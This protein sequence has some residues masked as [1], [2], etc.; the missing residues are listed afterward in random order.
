MWDMTTQHREHQNVF[1]VYL[2][3][4]LAGYELANPDRAE[5][6]SQEMRKS[7]WEEPTV[8]YFAQARIDDGRVNPF[9]PRGS[10]LTFASFLVDWNTC[11]VD[12][13][14]VRT[15]VAELKNVSPEETDEATIRWVASL[16][17]HVSVLRTCS[18]YDA[19]H[20]CY[21]DA[22]CAE[23]RAN[24]ASYLQQVEA[25]ESRLHRLL[26]N[27]PPRV[28][29]IIN[30]L[31]ADQLTDIVEIDGRAYVIVSHFGAESRVHELAHLSLDQ[32]LLDSE[33]VISGHQHLLEAVYKP[34]RC[35]SYAWDRSAASWY[36]VFSETLVRAVTAWALWGQRPSVLA[37]RL[38][39]IARE[40]FLFVHSVAKTLAEHFEHHALSGQGIRL[41]IDA[42]EAEAASSIAEHRLWAIPPVR[43]VPSSSLDNSLRGE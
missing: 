39:E 12:L 27:S 3:L 19:V 17:E 23:H 11:R 37:R 8:E 18:G 16:P 13:P 26:P 30:P 21:C 29:E 10:I 9:W 5:R 15:K 33:Q 31:Q 4:T 38:D 24:S 34:M 14:A 32:L 1:D 40:G 6:I 41:C 7:T 43:V 2:G 20:A 42:C 28:S 36:N 22:V 25:A 35:L